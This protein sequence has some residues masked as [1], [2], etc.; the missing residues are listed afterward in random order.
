[1]SLFD[2]KKDKVKAFKKVKRGRTKKDVRKL[3]EQMLGPEPIPT[4]QGENPENYGIDALTVSIVFPNEK[5]RDLFGKFLKI[6][7]SK[8]RK[9]QYVTDISLLINLVEQLDK[10]EL[11]YINGVFGSFSNRSSSKKRNMANTPKRRKL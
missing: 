4:Y 3:E 10:G 1:M 6:S 2:H 9:A 5:V 8:V 11:K 7:Y